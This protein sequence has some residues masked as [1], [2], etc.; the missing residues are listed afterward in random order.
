[1]PLQHYSHSEP[2]RLYPDEAVF[3]GSLERANILH[4]S[5]QDRVDRLIE[6]AIN[7]EMANGYDLYRIFRVAKLAHCLALSSGR[8]KRSADQ[9]STEALLCNVGMIALP[10]QLLL[11]P[12][13]LS[14]GEKEMVRQHARYGAELLRKSRL[15]LLQSAAVIAEQHHERYDGRGYPSGLSGGAIAED[16]R[17]VAICDAFDAMTHRRPWRASPLSIAAALDELDRGGATGQFDPLL[18]KAFV[19]LM[20]SELRE[21]EDLDRFLSDGADQLEY[22]RVRERMEAFIHRD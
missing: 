18:V 9:L 6:T 5:I 3:R 13:D 12:L 15:Q 19:N 22:V 16:A 7:A 10:A 20:T 2:I 8:D 11:K 14:I 1:M 21:I 17:I 4:A